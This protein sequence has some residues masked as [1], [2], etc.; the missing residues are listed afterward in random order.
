MTAHRRVW[1]SH[2]F[3]INWIDVMVIFSVHHLLFTASVRHGLL[4]AALILPM[5]GKYVLAVSPQDAAGLPRSLANIVYGPERVSNGDFERDADSDGV[6]DDWQ[7]NVQ[8]NGSGAVLNRHTDTR[9]GENHFIEIRFTGGQGISQAR[10]MRFVP[11]EAGKVYEL[12]YRYRSGADARLNADVLLTGTGPMYRTTLQVPSRQWQRRRVFFQ[13]PEFVRGQ[14]PADM[15]EVGTVGMY[16][17]NRSVVPVFYDDV[18]FRQTDLTEAELE[19]IVP[20]FLVQ[21]RSMADQLI[22]PDTQ[23]TQAVFL[24]RLSVPEGRRAED[25]RLRPVLLLADRRV[26]ALPESHPDEPITFDLADLPTG[27][28]RLA[29]QLCDAETGDVLAV[30]W[31]T[32]ERVDPSEFTE[33]P[34]LSQAAIF[35]DRAGQPFFPIIMFGVQHNFSD[36]VWQQLR[37][38]GFNTLH[39]YHF[40]GESNLETIRGYLDR[41]QRLGFHVMAG[42]PRRLAERR[43]EH[44]ALRSWLET[45]REHEA[46]LFYYADEMVSIRHTPLAVVRSVQQMLRQVDPQRRFL[47]YENPEPALMPLMDGLVVN[48]PTPSFA[49]LVR[50]RLGDDKPYIACF[51]QD[52]VQ[53]DP[54]PDAERLRYEM[55]MPVILGARGVSYWM[56][57][58]ARWHRTDPQLIERVMA[59]AREMSVVAPAVISEEP[60]PA[61]VSVR[62]TGETTYVLTVARAGQTYVLAGSAEGGLDGQVTLAAEGDWEQQILFEGGISQPV[63]P[64]GLSVAVPAGRVRVIRVQPR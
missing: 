3:V 29:V 47:A 32:V 54:A 20:A 2:F 48:L 59:S 10:V 62:S 31:Q 30:Q 16:V 61:S 6:P 50:L 51:G 36:E 13:I 19:Q 26:V 42:L 15:G 35:R 60:V 40:E 41:A 46:V 1:T 7:W 11:A 33:R 56:Y 34:D 24:P 25:W 38:S 63:P 4:L 28:N 18:S 55:F 45:V 53:A 8:T 5:V 52:H 22:F 57:S 49:T 9:N 23:E 39:D 37:D 12:S 64:E 21:P 17:Q 27:K 58:T 44:A 14:K 43:E